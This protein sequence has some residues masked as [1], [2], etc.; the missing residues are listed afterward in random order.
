MNAEVEILI[1]GMKCNRC[2]GAITER[3]KLVHGIRDIE[4]SLKT[5]S[6][7]VSYN[8]QVLTEDIIAELIGD[9]GYYTSVKK[10]TS[11]KVITS[12]RHW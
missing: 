11:G 5:R 2:V 9:M 6:A 3:M 8:P 10:I 7:K 1:Q 4:V 12:G